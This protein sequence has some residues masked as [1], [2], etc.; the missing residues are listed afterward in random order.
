MTRVLCV[1]VTD[2]VTVRIMY[3]VISVKEI[4]RVCNLSIIYLFCSN[5]VG[6]Q[7]RFCQKYYKFVTRDQS[8]TYQSL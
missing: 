1:N 5:F 2:I 7:V 3:I 6:V 8:R 4:L